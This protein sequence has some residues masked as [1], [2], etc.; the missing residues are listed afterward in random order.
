MPASTSGHLF[1]SPHDLAQRVPCRICA[2]EIGAP[3]TDDGALREDPHHSRWIMYQRSIR[4][5][6]FTATIRSTGDGFTEDEV[7][8]VVTS[9][10]GGHLEVLSEPPSGVTRPSQIPARR[11]R[12]QAFVDDSRAR[13]ALR[14]A[15]RRPRIRHTL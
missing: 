7:V 12:F 3:C 11:V 1:L 10:E 15:A 6:P 2:A 4:E 8:I 13:S 5:R 14:H 9:L